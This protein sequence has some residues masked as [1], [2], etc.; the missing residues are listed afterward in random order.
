MFGVHFPYCAFS[1]VLQQTYFFRKNRASDKK[2][3]EHLF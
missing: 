1:A 3:Q 2:S